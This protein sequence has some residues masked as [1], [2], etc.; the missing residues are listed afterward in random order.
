MVASALLA[1][2]ALLEPLASVSWNVL[3]R[4][5]IGSSFAISPHGVG[6]AL[7]F[8]TGAVVFLYES[9][10]RGYSEQVA[11]SIIVRALIGALIG[12]RLGYVFTHL[13]EFH[14]LGDV[15][16][17]Y[18]GGLSQLGGVAGAVLLSAVEVRRQKL[19]LWK[20]LDAA[21]IPIPLGVVIGRIGDLI[22]GDHLGK[23][24]S[25]LLAFRYRGGQLSGYLC[26][27]LTC[28]TTLSGGRLQVITPDGARLFEGNGRTLIGEGVGVHQTAL[29]DFLLTIALVVLLVVLNQRLRRP[30]VLFLSYMVWYGSG[31]I[32]TDFLRVENR[33]GGLTGSQWT[34]L[35]AVAF[36]ALTLARFAVRPER[37]PPEPAAEP[38]NDVPEVFESSEPFE[39]T[40]DP[41]GEG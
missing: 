18:R 30:G 16:A 5:R 7:G 14:S 35:I 28:S 26:E 31:R 32:L 1:P 27:R 22:I 23:P 8:L 12:S 34:S 4:F 41:S 3:D 6:I 15:L 40:S 38:P 19:P 11:N 13:S 25:W 37:P 2:L 29:Y 39:A 24:T 21:A 10:R 9:R 33:F 20:G 36:A 17:L